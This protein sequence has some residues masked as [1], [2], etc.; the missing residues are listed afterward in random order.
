[1]AT[2]PVPGPL[3]ESWP[4]VQSV[5]KKRAVLSKQNRELQDRLNK[6]EDSGRQAE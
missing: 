3:V 2:I 5:V 6:L 1:M 4:E